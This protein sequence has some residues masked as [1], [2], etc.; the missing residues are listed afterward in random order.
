MAA[1]GN[2]DH[3]EHLPYIA[4]IVFGEVLLPRSQE[5]F[6]PGEERSEVRLMS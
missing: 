5:K 1:A 4:I 6:C 2:M 3:I